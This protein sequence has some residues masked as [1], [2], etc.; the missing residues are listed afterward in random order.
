MC[1]IK[2]YLYR[3]ATLFVPDESLE[4]YQTADGWKHFV[5]IVPMSQSGVESIFSPSN[6]VPGLSEIADDTVISVFTTEGVKV[7]EGHK[8]GFTPTSGLYLVVTPAGNMKL[9]F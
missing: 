9:R 6:S 5:K 7:Y 8:G 1:T 3:N 4:A 2:N